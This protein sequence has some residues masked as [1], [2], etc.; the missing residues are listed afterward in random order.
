MKRSLPDLKKY[1]PAAV[2]FVVFL[3]AALA[4]PFD[5]TGTTYWVAFLFCVVS[6]GVL[7]F[8]LYRWGADETVQSRYYRMPILRV[9]ALYVAVQMTLGFI[10]MGFAPVC[11]VWVP[12]VLFV[13]LCG[14]AAVGVLFSEDAKVQ[15]E[16]IDD[17]KTDNTR[18]MKLLTQE[19]ATVT[20][21]CADPGL[22]QDLAA[23]AERFRYSDPVGSTV[24]IS[25]EDAMY[26][27]VT[28]LKGAVAE[29]DY[30]AASRLVSDLDELL[31]ERNRLCMAYKQ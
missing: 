10:V 9:S 19:M 6:V 11:P 17:E 14:A 29:R 24:T 13:A 7:T 5:K 20:G 25:V 18:R 28:R 31:E 23:L 12:L 22:S 15:I 21:R 8:V 16:K 4:I 2:L 30:A 1:L 26:R 27:A 3:V